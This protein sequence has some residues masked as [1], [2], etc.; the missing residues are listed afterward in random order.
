VQIQDQKHLGSLNID[1]NQFAK[2]KLLP[3]PDTDEPDELTSVS[4]L[5]EAEENQQQT[6]KRAKRGKQKAS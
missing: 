5:L 2:K 3:P 6:H 4:A 1:I